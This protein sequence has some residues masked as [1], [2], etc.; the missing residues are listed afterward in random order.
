MCDSAPAPETFHRIAAAVRLP[1]R[2]HADDIAT[3]I[4]TWRRL[5]ARRR[6]CG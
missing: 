3:A 1:R 2:P 5:A 4:A 6:C